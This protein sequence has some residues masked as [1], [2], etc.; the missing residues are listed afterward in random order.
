VQKIDDININSNE[1]LNKHEKRILQS[2]EIVYGCWELMTTVWDKKGV[3]ED[4]ELFN[5]DKK[6][7]LI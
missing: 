7:F 4:C 3:S 1:G 6:C 5:E 2:S